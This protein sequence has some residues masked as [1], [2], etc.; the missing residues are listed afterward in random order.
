MSP[1]PRDGELGSRVDAWA[2][3]W[4]LAS[5]SLGAVSILATLTVS[6]GFGRV[7]LLWILCAGGLLTAPSAFELW[8]RARPAVPGGRRR[9]ELTV[10]MMQ[11]VVFALFCAQGRAID[12]LPAALLIT[13][14]GIALPRLRH[15]PFAM[16]ALLVAV[17]QSGVA[18]SE[19]R[20]GFFLAAAALQVGMGVTALVFL[21]AR[22]TRRR[23]R[24]RSLVRVDVP[25]EPARA[26]RSRLRYA[27]LLT[28]CVL[29]LGVVLHG[30]AQPVARRTQ[31]RD[32][33]GDPREQRGDPL[34]EQWV[35]PG[36]TA[37]GPTTPGTTTSFPEG[38]DYGQSLDQ[39]GTD[40]ILELRVRPVNGDWGRHGDR[41]LLKALNLDEFT[42]SGI[43]LGSLGEAQ[44]ITDADDGSPDGWIRF[45]PASD[46]E[47][48]LE[49]TQVPMRVGGSD[50]A[51]VFRPEPI[52]GVDL[53][54]A[55]FDPAGVLT[56]AEGTSGLWRY[57]VRTTEDAARDARVE[58]ANAYV[59]DPRYL[60]LPADSAALDW[61]RQQSDAILRGAQDDAERVARVIAHFR[62]GYRYSFEGSGFQG[63]TSLVDFMR[64][65]EGFCTYYASASVLLLRLNGVPARIVTGYRAQT[66]SDEAGGFVVQSRDGHAWFEVPIEGRGWVAFDST[67]SAAIDELLDEMFG[68]PG[69]PGVSEWSEELAE[70]FR[71]W[72]AGEEDVGMEALLASFRELPAAV[73]STLRR[74]PRLASWLLVPLVA[75]LGLLW[76]RVRKERGDA[77]RESSRRARGSTFYWHRLLRALARQGIVKRPGETPREFAR[78]A[79]DRAGEPL[80]PLQRVAELLYRDR[81]GDVPLAPAE[82]EFVEEFISTVRSTPLAA[83]R[84]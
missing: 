80:V 76:R 67:P 26:M 37:G 15:D 18:A 82:A 35:E 46:D 3:A 61:M 39:L 83:D 10:A 57:R 59:P 4:V 21:H 8:K 24:E 54:E 25:D 33:A 32:R 66:W 1:A 29:A 17:L 75:L 43:V 47:F 74:H 58:D 27:A 31:P 23:I 19:L 53:A 77:P 81:F 41:W 12:V 51:P 64:R 50:Q 13:V 45:A 20:G 68:E 7:P 30:F 38:L 9:A 42:D 55:R 44:P 63:V 52:R 65:R 40:R 16:L 49:I 60:Q 70:T 72:A 56:S 11:L 28:G 34:A 5:A 69:A 36:S 84:D 73:A 48:E 2:R 79:V 6:I 62:S 14:Q 22:A 78:A 71:R